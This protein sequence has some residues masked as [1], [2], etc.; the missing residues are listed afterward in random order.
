MKMML[1]MMRNDDDGGDADDDTRTSTEAAQNR[2]AQRHH[3]HDLVRNRQ[4]TSM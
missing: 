2:W 4:D 1:I 3:K